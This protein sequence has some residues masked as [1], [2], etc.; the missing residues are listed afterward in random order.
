[1]AKCRRTAGSNLRDPVCFRLAV[2]HH[3]TMVSTRTCLLSAAV[4]VLAA[5]TS[6]FAAIDLRNASVERLDNGLTVILLE[7]RHFP[8]VSVQMLY[9]VGA[10]DEVTGKTGLA[11]FLEHMA[12]RD[13]RLFPGTELA[14][15]IYAV[16]GEWH[17]YTWI[18]QTTYYETV[19]EDQLDLLLRIESDRMDQLL[20][21][22]D[23]ID[24]ERGAVLSEMHMYENSPDSVL[25]DAVLATSF[26]QHP[27]RNNTIGLE[28]DVDSIDRQDLV[29]FYERHYVPANAVLAVVGDFDPRSV[30]RRIQEL[31][32]SKRSGPPTPLPH[33][34]EPLQIGLRR[35]TLHGP[36]ERRQFMIAY[37]AP[38]VND[39][40]YAA[41]LVL[42]ELLG[43]GSGVNFHQNDWGTPIRPDSLLHGAADDLTTWYPPSAQDYVFVIGGDAPPGRAPDAVERAV[44]THVGSALQRPPSKDALSAAIGRVLDEFAFDV[45]TT[46]DAAH[47]LAFFDGLGALDTL[48]ELPERVRAVTPADVQRAAQTWLAPERRTIGWYLPSA[49]APAGEP[50]AAAATGPLPAAPPRR[51]IAT[52]PV[53]VASV[54]RLGNGIPVIVQPS[55]LSSSVTLRVVVPAGTNAE[56]SADDPILGLDSVNRRVRPAGLSAAI[57]SAA[58]LLSSPAK[59]VPAAPDSVDP[60][61]RLEQTFARF[62]HPERN[63]TT[64]RTGP[65][66]IVVAGDV[67]AQATVAEL[68]KAFA[69]LSPS[70]PTRHAAAGPELA[71]TA[72]H[73]GVPLAQA[74]VGYLVPAPGPAEGMADAWRLSLYALCHD[75]EG[76]LGKRA[77]SDTGLAYFLDCRYRSDGTRAWITV[78]AGVDPSKLDAFRAVLAEEL[79]RLASEPPTEDEIAEAKRFLIGRRESAAQSNAELSTML[80]RQ[81]LWYGRIVPADALERRLSPVQRD[82]VTDAARQFTRGATIVV[83]E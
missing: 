40:D 39:P 1:M 24:A 76:R 8:V 34:I 80:A 45:E 48:F 46:E 37:R 59:P 44:E 69:D 20:I 42:Q 65:V 53:P 18:D 32:G 77:I 25:T 67:D 33:T 13:S 47:Q 27:Y 81:W 75:Y 30:G 11:H 22:A 26:L 78:A 52:E 82:A 23:A 19:P 2:A 72:V 57:D 83:I 68:D 70:V 60:E 10:R 58:A 43:G 36:G 6:A 71:D 55:T 66:L 9:R 63:P 54:T 5:A 50:A 73:L 14:G 62:M 51:P 29:D 64:A 15:R 38:S 79:E 41:F 35:I 28:S 17:G 56:A 4:L 21:R 61:T 74:E 16:G 49:P 7:D 12:F 31:F 3:R